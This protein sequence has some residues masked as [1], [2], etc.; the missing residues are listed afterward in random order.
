M[1]ADA[2]D[3]GVKLRRGDGGIVGV[4][5]E[6]A[7]ADF[8]VQRR[9]LAG[10]LGGEDVAVAGLAGFVAGVVQRLASDIADGVGAVVAVLAE[11]LGN[12]EAT[13]T[14]EDE[15]SHDEESGEAVEM[16]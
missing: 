5:V 7:V 9:V 1:T 6:R 13:D 2:E 14:P 11:A 8:A 16:R 12:D 10:L 15:E 3:G 4:F